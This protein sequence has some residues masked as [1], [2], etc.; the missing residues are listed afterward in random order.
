MKAHVCDMCG[1]RIYIGKF[2]IFPSND[3]GRKI[4]LRRAGFL[5]CLLPLGWIQMDVCE[6]CFSNMRKYCE[7]HAGGKEN[8]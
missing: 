1:R 5:F 8:K 4:F 6:E 7:D 2:R 3:E